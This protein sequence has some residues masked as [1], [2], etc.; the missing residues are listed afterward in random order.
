MRTKCCKFFNCPKTVFII[1]HFFC[2]NL[3]ASDIGFGFKFC[4]ILF[5]KLYIQNLLLNVAMREGG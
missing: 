1:A 4:L 2:R 3:F 5:D